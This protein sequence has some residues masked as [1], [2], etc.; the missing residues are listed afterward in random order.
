MEAQMK[1]K[2]VFTLYYKAARG[3]LTT[4]I[5]TS[6]HGQVKRMEPELAHLSPTFQ[7]TPT[8][9]HVNLD[10]CKVYR[11]TLHSGFSV[12]IGSNS[13]YQLRIRALYH[14]AATVTYR[15]SESSC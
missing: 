3:L 11:P 10:I 14:Q 1:V 15:S 12:V 6:N 5:V 7:V 13:L 8:E 2:I 4:D 9:G